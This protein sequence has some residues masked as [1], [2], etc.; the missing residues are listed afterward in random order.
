VIATPG[1]AA[2]HAADALVAAGVT[3]LLELRSDV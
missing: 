3:S 2:Q 1:P